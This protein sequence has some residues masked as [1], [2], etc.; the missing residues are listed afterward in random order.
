MQ[1]RTD[2]EFP[3]LFASAQPDT[4]NLPPPGL[5]SAVVPEDFAQG[6]AGRS[7]DRI[8]YENQGDLA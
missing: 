8:S 5:A 7:V 4:L 6:R 2:P 3:G 1:T